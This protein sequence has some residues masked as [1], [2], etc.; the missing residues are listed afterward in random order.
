M[1]MSHGAH[2]EAERY[3]IA[4]LRLD[5]LAIGAGNGPCAQCVGFFS[6]IALN[7]YRS[8]WSGALDW[9]RRW[10]AEQPDAP[11]R[12]EQRRARVRPAQCRSHDL[13]Q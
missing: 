6:I 1:L 3:A 12:P 9:G 7:W 2:Q 8:D 11:G 13:P 4:G 10:I 5:S